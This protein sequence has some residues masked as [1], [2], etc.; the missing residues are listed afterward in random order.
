[1]NSAA[2]SASVPPPVPAAIP[3]IDARRAAVGVLVIALASAAIAL[4]LTRQLP[5]FDRDEGRYSEAAREILVSGDWLVPR[6]FGVPYLEKPPLFYWLTAVSLATFGVD[7]LGARLVPALAAALGVLATGLFTLRTMGARAAPL[8]SL[9]LAT[10]GLYFVLARVVVTDMLFSV[11]IAGALMAFFVAWTEGRSYLPF[12][13][14]AAAATLT[15]GPVAGALCGFTIVGYLASRRDLRLLLA[16]RFWIGFPAYL[17][18]VGAWFG[19]AEVRVPGYLAFYVYKE[20]LLRVAGD[21]H[22]EGILWYVPWLLAGFLP[23]TP[24]LLAA[25]P[26]IA[27]R[28]REPTSAGEAAR[29]AAIWAAVVLVFFS[30]PRGKLAPY[31]LPM[32][33]PLAML[34]GDALARWTARGEEI[35]RLRLAFVSVGVVLAALAVATPVVWELAP[36]PMSRWLWAAGGVCAAAAAATLRLARRRDA[37]PVAAVAA[38]V[39]ALQLCAVP[40][41]APIARGLTIAPIIDILRERARPDDPIV[42]YSGYYPNLPFYLGRIPY[43]VFGNRELDFGVSVEGPGPFVVDSLRRVRSRIGDRPTFFVLHPRTRDVEAVR[44]LSGATRVLYRGRR[45][46]LVEHLP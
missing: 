46:V 28:V 43:F 45:S 22:R 21:E 27:R 33:P 13:L 6:L 7:E 35:P 25:L 41:A 3:M 31:I 1:M 39:A 20:H 15:K 40:I 36:V 14:L 19:L 9:V 32:F 30:L 24:M 12:W 29:F 10:A 42:L 18:L 4:A 2:A 17:A 44:G 23:W 38:A 26:A 8:A 11:A 16:P 5:L 34:L 37:S